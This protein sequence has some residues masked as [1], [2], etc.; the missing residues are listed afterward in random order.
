MASRSPEARSLLEHHSYQRTSDGSGPNSS[1]TTPRLTSSQSSIRLEDHRP[2]RATTFSLLVNSRGGDG[3]GDRSPPRSGSR[4]PP[5]RTSASGSR[6]GSISLPQ[7]VQINSVDHHGG[8]GVS[9][10]NGNGTPYQY[11]DGTEGYRIKFPSTVEEEPDEQEVAGIE[12]HVSIAIYVSLLANIILF[13]C[14]TFSAVASHSLSVAASAV[15]SFLDLASQ[16]IVVLA[17]RGSKNHDASL[18]PAGRSRLEAVGIILCSALMGMAA[19]QL[20][21]ESGKELYMG[22]LSEHG[23]HASVDFNLFTI[24]L[25]LLTILA[26]FV[27]WVYC[28]AYAKYS[29][30]LFTLAVDHRN[31]VLSN[32]VALVAALLAWQWPSAWSAD[33]IGAILMS[34]YI[35]RNWT[36]IGME[37]IDHVVGRAADPEFIQS[38]RELST[39]FHTQLT[40]DIIRAYHFGS[41]YLVELEVI[42][43]GDMTV[44]EA[45]D[46]SLALQQGL[47]QHPRI[48]RAFVH[49][50]YV[51]RGDLDEHAV[52]PRG[53]HR[54]GADAANAA[55][56][57]QSSPTTHEDPSPKGATSPKLRNANAS[58]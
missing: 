56:R 31:D 32:S 4:S 49:V 38:I 2:G 40:P 18:Y 19:L 24:S 3:G 12:R 34:L 58:Q 57:N 9:S 48:E 5:R 53:I 16:G 44:R 14:K 43:P 23:H 50:D 30:T 46:I 6:G 55:A 1:H 8:S 20:I 47:E 21:L 35:T 45:H 51:T 29:P 15:D 10:G 22:Y 52:T 17:E 13:V 28:N 11:G 27:L 26:K 7:Q 42:L 25:L 41:K 54:G 33:P 37:Q 36:E 39:N